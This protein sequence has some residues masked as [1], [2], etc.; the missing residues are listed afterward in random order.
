V[1]VFPEAQEWDGAEGYGAVT[2]MKRLEQTRNYRSEPK[3]G[4]CTVAINSSP[5]KAVAYVVLLVVAMVWRTTISL[6]LEYLGDG[7]VAF[8]KI[9][10]FVDRYIVLKSMD[11][12]W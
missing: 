5:P 11:G 12:C 8:F 1:P 2:R 3:F 6:M 10:L 9:Q 4:S 7:A